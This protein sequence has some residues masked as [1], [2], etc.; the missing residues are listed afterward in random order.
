[1]AK[2]STYSIRRPV[3]EDA[4]RLGYVHV[5]CWR[6]VYRNVIPQDFLDSL[7]AGE[8]TESWT[9]IIQF[10]GNNKFVAEVDGE[11]VGFAAS[12]SGRD[13]DAPR[14]TEVY[15]IYLLSPH[16]GSGLGQQLLNATID[17]APAYL[18]VGE[19]NA[20]AQA[21]YRR[22]GFVPDGGTRVEDFL[23]ADLPEIRMVR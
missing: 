15:S 17:D 5:T 21:F 23:G 18:W 9:Q 7:D 10:A 4:A 13:P 22:N 16:F 1:M 2:T 8:R 6:E 14:E 20:R 11:I 19:D 12:G 3:P